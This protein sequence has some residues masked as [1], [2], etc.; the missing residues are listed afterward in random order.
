MTIGAPFAADGAARHG[1]ASR[2]RPVRA[3]LVNVWRYAEEVFTFHEGRLL[4]RGVNG[5]GKSMA[6]ELLFPFLLDANA[7]PGR[8]SSAAK[9]RGGLYERLMTGLEGRDRVGFV[10]A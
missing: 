5:S 2:W 4:L 8:L 9:S 6:L 3:G 10:W 7:H 1:R